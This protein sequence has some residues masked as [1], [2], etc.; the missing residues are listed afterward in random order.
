M[1]KNIMIWKKIKNKYPENSVLQGK[2][3]FIAN[4]GFFLN[5]GESEIKGFIPITEILP[6]FEKLYPRLSIGIEVTGIIL[7]YAEERNQIWIKP[8]CS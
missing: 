4:F 7:G 8:I 3:E 5:I 1:T 2:I 6:S